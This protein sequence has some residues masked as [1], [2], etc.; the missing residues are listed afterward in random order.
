MREA[1]SVAAGPD[2]FRHDPGIAGM[3]SYQLGE[4][5]RLR[6]DLAEAELAYRQALRHGHDPQPGLALLRL[7]QGQPRSAVLAIRRALEE[8]RLRLDRTRLLPA[9]VEIAIAAD[10]GDFARI[11][12]AELGDAADALN[13]PYLE[14]SAC[15]ARGATAL[16]QG[17]P[18][19][20]LGQLR[21][22]MGIWG[23]MQAPYELARTRVLLAAACDALGDADS[24]R[25]ERDVARLTFEHLAAKHDLRLL[26]RMLPA[27]G[28]RGEAAG[29]RDTAGLTP[30]EV[31]VLGLVATGASNR[32][33]ARKLV[34]SE[35]TIARHVAN[36]FLKIGVSS[37]AA[38]TAYAYQHGVS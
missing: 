25:M 21:R 18:A 38:A 20:A 30:R 36:I 37:R 14:A 19:E 23:A 26:E 7:A 32:S 17:D 29:V 3:A 22:S 35:K 1:L 13:S 6:G 9:A 4:L 33:I 12:A 16:A 28:P 2:K 34:L 31:E 27:H 24:A 15:F 5:H 11:A 8:N 10:D